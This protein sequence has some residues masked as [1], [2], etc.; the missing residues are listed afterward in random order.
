MQEEAYPSNHNAVMTDLIWHK[1]VLLKVSLFAWRLLRNRL[2][3]KDNLFKRHAISHASKLCV[4]GCGSMESAHHLFLD[5]SFFCSLWHLMR[6]WLGLCSV[7]PNGI[8]DHL[9]QFGHLAGASKSRRSVVL[10]IW[11]ACS[12]VI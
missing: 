6:S 7:D 2:S 4:T 12:W 1:N 9:V 11:F 5:C 3:T 10:T 8:S